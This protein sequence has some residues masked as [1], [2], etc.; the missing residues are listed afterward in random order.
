MTALPAGTA[1]A[2]SHFLPLWPGQSGRKR[3]MFCGFR[4]MR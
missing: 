1:S 3:D 4:D 2:M